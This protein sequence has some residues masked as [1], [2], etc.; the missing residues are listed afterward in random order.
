MD[1]KSGP[2]RTRSFQSDRHEVVSIPDVMFNPER[3]P[4][5]IGMKTI[6]INV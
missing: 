4:I 5:V 6:N 1:F 3:L 2:A